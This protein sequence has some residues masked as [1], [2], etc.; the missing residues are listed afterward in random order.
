VA[1][2]APFKYRA[3]L[4]Y[5]HR[6]RKWG[7]WL[8][9]ALEHHRIDRDLVGRHTPAGPVV[10]TL[11]PIFRDRE[12]FSAGPSLAEQTLAALEASQFLIVVCSP[13]AAKSEYVNEE[14]RRFKTMG[15]AERVIPIIVDGEPGHP[16]RECFPP[17]LRFKL[18]EDGALTAEREEP[19]AADAR[20][21]G[22]GRELARQK[23][24]AGLLG[25]GLDEIVRRA[26]RARRRR[27]RFWAALA[28][29]FLLLAVT[30]AGSAVYAW[31]QLKTN[32]AFL[33]ATL[34]RFTSIVNRAVGAAQ[35]Y[36]LPLRVTLGFLEEAEGMLNVMAQYGRPTPRMRQRQIA[37][38]IA[39]ADNYRDLGRTADSE[40][41]IAEAQRLASELAR[42][43]A[44]NPQWRWEQARAHQRRGDIEMAKGDLAAALREFRL[45]REIMERL[46]RTD[47]DN[48][49]WQRDLSLAYERIGLVQVQQGQFAEAAKTFNVVL[50][51]RQ[52]LASAAPGNLERQRDLTAAYERIGEMQRAHGALAD[53]LATFKVALAIAERLVKAEP[54]NAGFQR[55]L[56]V[57]H[58]NVGIILHAQGQSGSALVSFKAALAIVDGLANADPQN[59]EW[60]RDLSVMHERIGD[61]LSVLK[62]FEQAL[63][64]YKALL[65][66]RDRLAAAD[67]NNAAWQGD[68][69]I[70]HERLGSVYS[71]L[72]RNDE[73]KAALERALA[74]YAAALARS[75]D[76]ASLLFGSAMPLMRLGLMH[77]EEGAPYLEK[78]LAILKRLDAAGRLD[79]RRR[80][81]IV[82]VERALAELRAKRRQVPQ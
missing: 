39:F 10:P 21:Q 53:A 12:D 8:H 20:E 29:V 65:A 17:A 57:A 35:S 22:D 4:S 24:V 42:D 78:A 71:H 30:A 27:N 73:A 23:L 28:G 60:Q 66:I 44:A 72:R 63:E 18:G 19:I 70:G 11:R 49:S 5:S 45:V 7:E 82:T 77:G 32:E 15:R 41:R 56:A 13:H 74:I 61:A 59:V 69:A 80:P 33:D 40:R 47:P 3:F 64:S 25:V 43:D 46:T 51:L 76:N 14:V 81:M 50:A 37:M 26:E 55:G 36:S 34:D 79:P 16:D 2:T 1:E 67:P 31:Q 68:L 9:R 58:N 54:G 38:L 52:R 75:P 62:H 6:D 48:A